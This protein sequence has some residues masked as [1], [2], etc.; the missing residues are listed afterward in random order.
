MMVAWARMAIVKSSWI[1]ICFENKVK[2]TFFVE[3]DEACEKKRNIEVDSEA[4][5]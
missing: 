5:A 1:Q 3:L 4:L 2:R